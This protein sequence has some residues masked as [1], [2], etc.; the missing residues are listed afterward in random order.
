MGVRAPASAIVF[1]SLLEA[2]LLEPSKALVIPFSVRTR[3]PSSSTAQGIVVSPI[4]TSPLCVAFGTPHRADAAALAISLLS[5]GLSFCDRARPPA[6]LD[7]SFAML[8]VSF[9]LCM[10]MQ[11]YTEWSCKHSSICRIPR[12]SS[13]ARAW[14][15]MSCEWKIRTVLRNDKASCFHGSANGGNVA[16]K[17]QADQTSSIRKLRR[18]SAGVTPN[19]CLNCWRSEV[20]VP[21]PTSSAIRSMG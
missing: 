1:F 6:T 17:R 2:P 12:R 13:C 21:K 5:S 7:S 18:H 15:G 9:W 10:Q 3:R 14:R 11:A 20:A 8:A 19:A 16:R 4:V